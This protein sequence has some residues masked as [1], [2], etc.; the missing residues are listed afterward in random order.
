MSKKDNNMN[1]SN[2]AKPVFPSIILASQSPRRKEILQ[3]HGHDPIIFPADID[4]FIPDGMMPEEAT[5][6]L[7]REKGR[8]VAEQCSQNDLD[9]MIIASDTVVYKEEIL[10]KPVDKAHAREMIK[11]LRGENH[12]VITGVCLIYSKLELEHCFYEVTTVYCKD[13]SDDEVEEYISTNEPYDKAGGYGIQGEF[14][15]YIDHI[16]GDYENVVGL[17][18]DRLEKELLLLIDGGK[19]G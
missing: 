12:K 19:D 14:G 2:R 17:P 8:F 5:M 4:E 1:E 10:G 6:Y 3:K 15:K 13:I 11:S 7:A 16:E 18:Y 9:S